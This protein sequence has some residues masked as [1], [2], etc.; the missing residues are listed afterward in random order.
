MPKQTI[1][2]FLAT[3]RKAKGYTQQQ[4]ADMIGVSNRTLSSWEQDRTYPDIMLLPVIA[5]IFGVTVDEIL[6][7]ERRS[8]ADE[9]TTNELTQKSQKKILKNALNKY[10]IKCT[11]LASV[12]L[13]GSL[14]VLL[15]FLLMSFVP[16]WLT[17]LLWIL[18]AIDLMVVA[19]L[20]AVFEKSVLISEEEESRFTLAVKRKTYRGVFFAGLPWI[21]CL[22]L[23]MIFAFNAVGTLGW[24][25]FICL[26]ALVAIFIIVL[27]KLSKRGRKFFTESELMLQ[28]KNDKLATKIAIIG[29]VIVVIMP[30][31][32]ST[33]EYIDFP[34]K[35]NIITYPKD[36]FIRQMQTVQLLRNTSEEYGVETAEDWTYFVDIVAAYENDPVNLNIVDD[37]VFVS[38]YE[39]ELYHIEGNLYLD[40][41]FYNGYSAAIYYVFYDEDFDAYRL[42]ELFIGRPVY[43]NGYAYFCDK[44]REEK[45]DD[46]I[47]AL[48][49]GEV[50]VCFDDENNYFAEQFYSHN[51]I[52]GASAQMVS[53]EFM[54][55]QEGDMYSL[56]W[57]AHMQYTDIINSM[58]VICIIITIVA[59]FVI[60]F[61]LRRKI[62]INI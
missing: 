50:V 48:R 5:E 10:S 52:F 57:I 32:A 35:D 19:V 20:F 44:Y 36:E 18:A 17:V 38:Y 47:N 25:L 40:L 53:S 22:S 21:V 46:Y 43:L 49:G 8:S 56:V 15:S 29:I 14:L 11:A 31:V 39:K 4:V 42:V 2:E 60:Y 62:V 45:A 59:C 41:H 37:Y 7:G 51:T 3:Q 58:A 61:T 6:A 34:I 26:F 33:I 28:K 24:I 55:E 27:L 1:G 30:I 13:G 12:G 16:A 9:T 23:F 54:I